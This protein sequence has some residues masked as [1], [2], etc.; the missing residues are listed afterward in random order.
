MKPV[1]FTYD[2]PEDFGS[3][4]RL[5]STYPD[6]KLLAGG[7]SLGPMMNFRVVRPAMLIDISRLEELRLV[8]SSD[9]RIL[10]GSAV[11]HCDFEDGRVESPIG[12]LFARVGMGIAYR[13]VRNRGTVGGSLAH[14]DP[15]A[16]WPAIMLALDAELNVRSTRGDRII[17]MKDFLVGPL[18]TSLASDE[19][20]ATISI[21]R[22]GKKARYGRYKV[23][24]QPGEFAEAA[25]VIMADLDRSIVRTVVSGA[26]LVPFEMTSTSEAVGGLLAGRN[27]DLEGTIRS[28]VAL[29]GQPAYESRL[30]EACLLRAA[31][32]V[33][34]R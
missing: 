6:S 28:E 25:A 18:E 12:D 16:D 20:I 15:A 9:A 26:K 13:A 8:E 1:N 11:R 7:Q 23:S 30:F 27:V 4:L 32:E 29:R 24:R 10:V 17:R 14:S 33:L 34:G 19:A 3:A 2:R 21:P 5:L 31:N 22:F